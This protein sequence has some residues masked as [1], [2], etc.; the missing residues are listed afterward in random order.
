M[1]SKESVARTSLSIGIYWAFVYFKIQKKA[2]QLIKTI[3]SLTFLTWKITEEVKPWLSSR[4]GRV[5]AILSY[6]R[7]H[8]MAVEIALD[9]DSWI[10]NL[11]CSEKIR[12]LS[13]A[14]RG[15]SSIHSSRDLR[16]NEIT[17]MAQVIQ[18]KS[19]RLD[20][21]IVHACMPPPPRASQPATCRSHAMAF[22]GGSSNVYFPNSSLDRCSHTIEEEKL[23][24]STSQVKMRQHGVA[25]LEAA[26][27]RGGSSV[28]RGG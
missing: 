8:G 17:H 14:M 13:Y 26:A 11:S 20:N 27:V 12:E 6:S 21:I 9:F 3:S 18:K 23:C 5:R 10:N 22:K 16:G 15:Y 4:N 7:P 1:W 24:R 28:P 19:G 2:S 25:L